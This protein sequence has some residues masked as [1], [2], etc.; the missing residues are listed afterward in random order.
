MDLLGS[1]VCPICG[2]PHDTYSGLAMHMVKMGDDDH[3]AI[4]SI[5]HGLEL[6]AYHGILESRNHASDLMN[7]TAG[8][9]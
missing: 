5:D 9:A 7:S 8:Y 2:S 4:E 6:I 3:A 1:K